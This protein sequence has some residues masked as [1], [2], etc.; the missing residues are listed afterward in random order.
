M[1]IYETLLHDGWFV[2]VCSGFVTRWVRHCN[3]LFASLKV[4][5]FSVDEAVPRRTRAAIVQWAAI[6]RLRASGVGTA[7][8]G[9]SLAKSQ[10]SKRSQSENTMQTGLPLAY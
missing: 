7:A 5:V 3:C 4:R 2:G 6:D 10:G 8:D 9:L 1:R